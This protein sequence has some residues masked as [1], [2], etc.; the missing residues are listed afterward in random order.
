LMPPQFSDMIESDLA[1]ALEARGVTTEKPI[2]VRVVS[3]KRMLFE[4]VKELKQR[5]GRSGYADEFPYLSQAIFVFQEVGGRDVCLFTVYTQEYDEDCP[6]PN[7]NRTY[8]S[9]VD[10]VPYLESDP[11]GARSTVYHTVLGGY[12]RYAAAC[13]FEHAHL[14]VAPPTEGTE[15]F[16]H[17][18]PDDGRPPMDTPTLRKWYEKL[19]T[20]AKEQGIV[21][22]FSD[23]HE[24]TAELTSVRD[25]PFFDGDFFPDKVHDVIEKAKQPPPPPPA[26][27]GKAKAKA[28]GPP[29]L[30][31][32][33]TLAIADGMRREA[34]GS[35]EYAFL[36]AE[37]APPAEV[38]HVPRERHI[39]PHELVDDREHFL[40]MCMSRHW[41]CDELRRAQWTTMMMLA[42]LGG[43]PGRG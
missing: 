28:G 3:R 33:E 29:M 1:E 11:P 38:M 31:R 35:T 20:R 8:I 34:S 9:Y 7:T 32:S 12:L 5:Y 17:C 24:Y 37:L 30:K 25:F 40:E 18:R 14:W 27:K 39:G 19:L 42:A 43:Q 10:S 21:R 16:F 23:L 41:Q 2:V 36:V 22:A 15:Y 6:P 26:A 13:G 4:A